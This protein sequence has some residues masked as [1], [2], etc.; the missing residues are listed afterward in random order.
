MTQGT[1]YDG[2]EDVV[3]H[4]QRCRGV[5]APPPGILQTCTCSFSVEAQAS[6]MYKAA[7]SV[8]EVRTSA[9]KA[10]PACT[11]LLVAKADLLLYIGQVQS[12]ML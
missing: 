1:A 10:H 12:E 2:G 6:G 7:S 4:P 5:L 3:H 8:I 9:Y 11:F